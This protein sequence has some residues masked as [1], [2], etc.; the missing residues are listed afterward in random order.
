[1]YSTK[2]PT[3]HIDESDLKC[4]N[5]E[6]GCDFYGNSEWEGYCSKC[7]RDQLQKD[8]ARRPGHYDVS[9]RSDR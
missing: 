5:A 7:H 6:N 2:T 8:K 1:M 4:K 3:L 9:S